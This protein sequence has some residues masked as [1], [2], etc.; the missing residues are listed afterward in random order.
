M[1]V[2]SMFDSRSCVTLLSFMLNAEAI[3][4]SQLLIVII[5]KTQANT[6]HFKMNMHSEYRPTMSWNQKQ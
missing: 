2:F 4:T 5:K 1:V 6:V 3:V